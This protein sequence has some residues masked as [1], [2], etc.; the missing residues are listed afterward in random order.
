MGLFDSIKSSFS[1]SKKPGSSKK[2]KAPKQKKKK[3]GGLFGSKDYI[4]KLKIQ[5]VA[6]NS[7][8]DALDK[9]SKSED[10]PYVKPDPDHNWFYTIALTSDLIA[11]TPLESQLGIIKKC[12]DLSNL[13]GDTD[14][15]LY[16]A[17]FDVDLY[18]K[19]KDQPKQLV[20][21]PT[22][23]TLKTLDDLVSGNQEIKFGLTI[24]PSDINT[25]NLDDYI[26]QGQINAHIDNDDGTWMTF[27]L[28][29]LE[30]FIQEHVQQQEA[31]YSDGELGDVTDQQPAEDTPSDEG[32]APVETP[33][34]PTAEAEDETP[35]APAA[36]EDDNYGLGGDDLEDLPDLG[37]DDGGSSSSDDD[38][39]LQDAPSVPSDDNDTD[40]PD[41]PDIGDDDED[42]DSLPDIGDDD[43]DNADDLPDIDDDDD[44]DS[45]D[46]L[47]GLDDSDDDK[48][49]TDDLP[50]I[51]DDD[52]NDSTDD[53]PDIDDDDDKD[54]DDDLPDLDDDNDTQNQSSAPTEPADSSDSSDDALPDLSDGD[55]E[56]P[57]LDD[58]SDE[59]AQT[60]Q[61]QTTEPAASTQSA[62]ST[63]PTQ[64]DN[65][66]LDDSLDQLPNLD[67]DEDDTN[68]QMPDLSQDTI[69]NQPANITP[70]YS[71]I[72]SGTTVINPNP[73]YN[74][75]SQSQMPVNQPV[76]QASQTQ[77][78]TD[79]L[80]KPQEIHDDNEVI[81]LS[82]PNAFDTTKIDEKREEEI[83][84]KQNA[85]ALKAIKA[86]YEP[87]INQLIKSI[88]IPIFKIDPNREFDSE[89]VTRK[90]IY[91]DALRNDAQRVRDEIKAKIMDQIV[92]TFKDV[93]DPT[94]FPEAY[95]QI[96]H[97]LKRRF[98]NER[99]LQAAIEEEVRKITKRYED[100]K[101]NTIQQAIRNAKADFEKNRVPVRD[102]EISQVSTNIRHD[103]HE[104]YLAG[105][106]DVLSQQRQ[107]LMPI[108]D[109]KVSRIIESA[110][111]E[112]AS[113]NQSIHNS[114][115]DYANKLMQAIEINKMLNNKLTPNQPQS[116]QTVSLQQYNQLMERL[117]AVTTANN[118]TSANK[119][120]QIRN[121]MQ[122]L[123]DAQ[124]NVIDAKREAADA[125]KR[126]TTAQMEADKARQA[127]IQAQA[128]AAQ[129]NDL[130]GQH[131]TQEIQ[132]LSKSS[133][134]TPATPGSSLSNPSSTPNPDV[135]DEDE[136]DPTNN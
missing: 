44:K 71:N 112:I 135:M 40:E 125:N 129:R 82:N 130:S 54:N 85:D 98:E 124:Q 107:T 88:K 78:A 121:L 58:G 30:N 20:F 25:S 87:R 64:D 23:N 70:D 106:D 49:S 15:A 126:A 61:P 116:N 75:Q 31:D 136:L 66:N 114:T 99:D 45:A 120:Q 32:N 17:S 37:D 117:N 27:S 24:L 35:D 53:L 57:D 34:A 73:S 29:D 12:M 3:S 74:N 123:N 108:L 100:E 65:L 97:E 67:E 77:S 11:G 94:R 50:D 2:T 38:D 8:F 19:S 60:A 33:D 122:Q 43:E 95:P 47:P 128:N 18:S 76:N 26:D 113:A 133:P 90:Q 10:Q 96:N 81:D 68:D 55:D 127:A 5:P 91:N 84:G 1:S 22:V 86:Q 80:N 102:A 111:P 4:S 110:S 28:N 132:N 104:T 109:K 21:L 52:D 13:Q 7:F 51:D 118:Q 93:V 115:K 63:Q 79:L 36:P 119:D 72:Q 6:E 46:D 56:L 103:A 62:S 69:N 89:V 101:Q 14:G 39:D 42:D 48:D 92:D 59:T 131:L 16:N 9:F 83:Y 41:L 134:L 105:V